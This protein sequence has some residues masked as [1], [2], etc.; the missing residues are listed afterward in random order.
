MFRLSDTLPT[1]QLHYELSHLLLGDFLGEGVSRKV[2]R[3]AINPEFV[4]KVSDRAHSWQNINEWEVWWYSSKTMAK[5]L[6][7]CV[8]ISPSGTYL[9][10]RYAEPL[11]KEDLPKKLPR[12]LVD[13]KQENFGMIGGQVVARDYGTMVALVSTVQGWRKANWGDGGYDG[14]TIR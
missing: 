7:P 1:E 13:Q 2:F 11:R 12:F 8:A 10:Q 3:C 4:V 9:I 6:A 5:W 14:S